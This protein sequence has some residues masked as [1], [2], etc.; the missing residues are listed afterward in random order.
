[1]PINLRAI[2]RA[3]APAGIASGNYREHQQQDILRSVLK[4]N[5]I[6][7]GTAIPKGFEEVTA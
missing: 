5:H 6:H 3:I 2:D 1:V 7:A 4:Q